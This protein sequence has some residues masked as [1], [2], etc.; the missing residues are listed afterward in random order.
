MSEIDTAE[1]TM[2]TDNVN[3]P[4]IVALGCTAYEGDAGP[5]IGT[6]ASTALVAA[7]TQ[8]NKKNV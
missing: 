6:W 7:N 5:G 3:K 1:I 4:E 2:M 8:I